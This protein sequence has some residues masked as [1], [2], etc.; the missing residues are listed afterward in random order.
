MNDIISRIALT[1]WIII[2]PVVAILNKKYD[3]F[4]PWWVYLLPL[5]GPACFGGV[6]AILRGFFSGLN[7]FQGLKK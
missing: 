5:Y 1:G 4:D 2:F 6:F 3:Y 7:K